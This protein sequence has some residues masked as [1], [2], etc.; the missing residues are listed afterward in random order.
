MKL[1]WHPAMQ[2]MYKVVLVKITTS[3]SCR[4][5]EEIETDEE[6]EGYKSQASPCIAD[7]L[8][9]NIFQLKEEMKLMD[10]QFKVE[11]KQLEQKVKAREDQLRSANEFLDSQNVERE[12]DRL[13]VL[14]MTQELSRERRSKDKEKALIKDLRQQVKKMMCILSRPNLIMSCVFLN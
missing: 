8:D 13:E 4:I 7:M 3:C 2:V 6:E 12:A 5:L 14:Q 1:Y 11:Y 10:I 9:D